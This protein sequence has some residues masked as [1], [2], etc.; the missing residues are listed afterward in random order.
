MMELKLLPNGRG[1]KRFYAKGEDL[2]FL[3]C[4]CGVIVKEG[5]RCE[6]GKTFCGLCQEKYSMSR[7]I[8]DNF[9]EHRHIKFIRGKSLK[10]DGHIKL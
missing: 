1:D 7:C 2:E 9:G 3:C 6:D 8:H 5:F 4:K 10:E